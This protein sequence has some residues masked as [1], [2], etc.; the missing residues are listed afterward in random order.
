MRRLKALVTGGAGF[1]GSHLVD[2]LLADGYEVD[3]LD[4][5]SCGRLENLVHLKD[6][7]RFRFFH[8][9]MTNAYQVSECVKGKDVVFH[10]A[11]QADIRKSLADHYGDLNQNLVSMVHLLEA[12]TK[13]GVPDL[14]FASSSAIYG[15]ADQTP[16]PETFM[17]V[18]TSLYGASKLAGEA[19]AQ[20]FVQFAPIK[21]RSFRFANVIGERCRRGVVWNFVHFLLENPKVL[22][23]LGDGQQS[24]EYIHVSDI[25]EGMMVGYRKSNSRVRVEAFNLGH[26]T[27]TTV[28]EIAGKVIEEMGLHGVSR[29]YAGGKRGWI[30]DNP[31]CILSIEKMKA[32]GWSP[33]VSSDEAIRRTARW[34]IANPA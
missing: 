24:K 8:A 10:L 9:D 3:A 12:M 4:N 34:T 25:I 7:S 22:P 2:R 16:T 1:I 28:D 29:E 27:N 30:G 32:L 19:F 20:A 21:V 33:K 5:L 26:P 17:P 6:D 18:Q 11:G 13:H 31:N 15:E 23:I 14:V